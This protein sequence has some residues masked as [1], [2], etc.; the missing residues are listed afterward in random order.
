MIGAQ[1]DGFENVT[2]DK[3]LENEEPIAEKVI[4]TFDF[5]YNSDLI[6]KNL[7]KEIKFLNNIF[8]EMSQNEKYFNQY[9]M[10]YNR[11]KSVNK[12]TNKYFK[13]LL[14]YYSQLRQQASI[15]SVFFGSLAFSE[16]IE[17]QYL[18]TK[19]E[20]VDEAAITDVYQALR[21]YYSVVKS[22]VRFIADKLRNARI[23]L[24]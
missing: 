13:I 22:R 21:N 15:S 7:D 18:L 17:I 1:I 14:N 20:E 5:K 3:A 10:A 4:L 12:N 19:F 11:T 6:K 9:D 2:L 23:V 16:D 8:N 24:G